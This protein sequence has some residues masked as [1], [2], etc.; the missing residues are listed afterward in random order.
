MAHNTT[1]FNN[2]VID[3][4]L[5]SGTLWAKCNLG[6]EKEVDF[7]LFY[8][9]GDTEGYVSE[10][11]HDFNWGAYKWG[12]WDQLTKYNDTDDKSVLDNGDD[13][14]YV[15]TDGKM[16]SPTKEQLQELEE[17]TNY[18]WTEIDGVK[19]MKFIN[20]SD[21]TKY[22]FIPAA[23]GCYDSGHDGVG[24]WGYV[25]SSSRYSGNPNGAWGMSFDSGDVD[26]G[27][28]YRCNGFNMRGV[29]N[30]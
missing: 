23:G 24:S 22:I 7:G 2:E 25:W 6:A 5:P 16:K 9:W 27:D 17:C 21:D 18:E 30:K 19:G 12:A 4:G 11:A 10:E 1:H 3:L 15:A 29:L 14:V 8:Q 28:D 26:M 13:P 20:K